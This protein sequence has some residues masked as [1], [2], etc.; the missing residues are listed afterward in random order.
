MRIGIIICDRYRTCGGGKCLRSMRERAGAFSR[1]PADEPL[2]L[3]GYSTCDGCPGGNVEYVPEEMIKNGAAG[4]PPGHGHGGRVPSLPATWAT[5][6]PS[7]RSGTAFRWWWARIPS[8]RSTAACTRGSS[9][10]RSSSP[11]RSSWPPPKYAAHTTDDHDRIHR[12]PSRP[13][14]TTWTSSASSTWRSSPSSGARAWREEL[15]GRAPDGRG[16]IVGRR[17]A[18]VVGRVGPCMGWSTSTA[19]NPCNAVASGCL[20]RTRSVGG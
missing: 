13:S 12:T 6:R 14:S 1:Y 18:S 5:S 17:W 15:K 10:C 9:P 2:E 16:L 7:S 11:R 20:I 3:V 8:P 4:H 19:D